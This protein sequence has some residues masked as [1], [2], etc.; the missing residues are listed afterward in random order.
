MAAASLIPELE[1]VVRH[2]STARR[3]EM[4]RRITALFVEGASRFNSE[5]VQL[6]GDVLTRLSADVDA[7]SRLELADRLAAIRNAPPDLVR[8]LAEDDDVAVARAV[9]KRSPQLDE[10]DLAE[11][12]QSSSQ[13]HLVAL[14]KRKAI[15]ATVTDI[16]VERG[17]RD[18]LRS[19]AENPDAQLS[20][21]SFAVLIERA[22]QDAALAEKVGLRPDIPPRLL[23]D[24]LLKTTP[25]VQR[26]LLASAKPEIQSEIRRVLS[27]AATA[28]TVPR[29]YSAA[30][31]AIRELHEQDRL[32]EARIVDFA[33]QRQYQ[34][35]VAGLAALCEVSVNVV[36][37]LMTSDRP[38]PILILCKA[39]GWGWA[40][41]RAIMAAIPQGPAKSSTELD[42]AFANFERLSPTTAQR[43]MRFWQVQH[44]QHAPADDS[45]P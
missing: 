36:D 1:D 33:N 4:L 7:Q 15:G 35:L 27:E 32:D 24:L 25:T 6:F 22:V 38:D 2:G 44:W 34:E 42:A 31:R 29:D 5:H 14:S 12:A 45:N 9:L 39:A 43:V 20:P 3:A 41:V 10:R 37:R 23:R 40:T 16:L 26:R 18:V 30:E 8:R 11:I 28:D 19:V 13:A 17:E 21:A